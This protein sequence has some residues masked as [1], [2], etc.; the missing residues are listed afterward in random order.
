MT[1]LATIVEDGLE[2]SI[3]DSNGMIK[4]IING[5]PVNATKVT[6]EEWHDKDVEQK[7]ALINYNISIYNS[8][9]S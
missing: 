1:T 4:F 5:T 9:R 7:E 3:T 2:I 8:Y 6:V